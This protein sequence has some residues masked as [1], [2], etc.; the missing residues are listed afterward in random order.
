M[1][2]IFADKTG[3][4]KTTAFI[5]LLELHKVNLSGKDLEHLRRLYVEEIP[6]GE[7]LAT[8]RIDHTVAMEGGE[9]WTLRQ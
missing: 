7:V 6:Y 8:L 2:F 4:I 9:Y 1:N 3:K 5:S